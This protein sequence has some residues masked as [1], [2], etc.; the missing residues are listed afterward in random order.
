MKNQ[1]DSDIHLRRVASAIL[2]G[3]AVALIVAK[4]WGG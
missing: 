2:L 1:I 3:A 4:L